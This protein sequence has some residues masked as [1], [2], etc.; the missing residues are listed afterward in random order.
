MSREDESKSTAVR[1]PKTSITICGGK[2]TEVG[3]AAKQALD[4]SDE[5]Y[6]STWINLGLMRRLG[7]LF[8]GGVESTG[9]STGG[10][11]LMF[12]V[13]IAAL[14]L[15]AF[16]Q[17]LIVFAVVAVLALLSGGA[18]L[19]FLRA[20]YITKPLNEIDS[21]KLEEFIR[22]QASQ[23]HIVKV[24]GIRD[25]SNMGKDTMRISNAAL[26]YRTGIQFSILVASAFLILE[27]AYFLATGHWLSG[28]S[29]AT[30]QME[31]L[32]L[33]CF[34]FLFV[35]GVVMMEIGVLL[36]NRLWRELLQKKKE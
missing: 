25:A 23:G 31:T 3:E 34:G 2:K 22:A 11:V 7:F 27:V 26:T 35:G 15:F 33:I 1:I 14:A 29:P 36:R 21:T 5:D 28:P 13:L 18:A 24:E 12:I 17:V 20:T 9:S 30:G 4:I 16:W 8:D 6:Y 19:K 10:L 32:V